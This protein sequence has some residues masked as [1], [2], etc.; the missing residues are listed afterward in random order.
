LPQDDLEEIFTSLEQNLYA[1]SNESSGL[2]L[3][4]PMAFIEG[5]KA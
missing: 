5:E 2:S 3:T 4:V 1:Y